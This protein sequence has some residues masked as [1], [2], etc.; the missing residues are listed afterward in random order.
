MTTGNL[1]TS[2]VED[3]SRGPQRR[4]DLGEAYNV[5]AE[6]RRRRSCCMTVGEYEAITDRIVAIEREVAKVCRDQL[7]LF[8]NQEEA[9]R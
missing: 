5:I 2:G 1:F 7:E 6:L 4:G 9:G 8:Y 3:V